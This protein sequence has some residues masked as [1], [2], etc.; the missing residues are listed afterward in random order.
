[1]ST[2]KKQLE[3]Q[4]ADLKKQ[5][6]DRQAVHLAQEQDLMERQAQ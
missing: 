3:Q 1:M 4:I 6:S 2:T 5:L